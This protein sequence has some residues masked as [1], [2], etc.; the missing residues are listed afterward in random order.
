MKIEIEIVGVSKKRLSKTMSIDEVYGI[1]PEDRKIIEDQFPI[2]AVI[3]YTRYHE[4]GTR[5]EVRVGQRWRKTT[6]G[7]DYI[8]VYADRVFAAG[9]EERKVFFSDS[10]SY[11]LCTPQRVQFFN[12]ARSVVQ[13]LAEKLRNGE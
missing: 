7:A 13:R 8:L 9:R 12:E 10:T 2:D 4:R 5:I 6:G 1:R 11:S 3:S